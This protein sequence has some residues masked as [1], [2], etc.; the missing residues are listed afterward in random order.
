MGREV[1]SRSFFAFYFFWLW[2]GAA[3]LYGA[4]VVNVLPA[5]GLASQLFPAIPLVGVLLG[6]W[7]GWRGGPLLI[8][9]AFVL[10]LLGAAETPWK[11]RKQSLNQLSVQA[12]IGWFAGVFIGAGGPV[13]AL[14]AG[15]HMAASVAI[16]FGMALLVSGMRSTDVASASRRI[17]A[18]TAVALSLAT[19]AVAERSSTWASQPVAVSAT[20]AIAASV[21]L[22][23]LWPIRFLKRPALWQR[24]ENV[25]SVLVAIYFLDPGSF[26]SGL[27]KVSGET[28]R[29]RSVSSLSGRLPT[30]LARQVAGWAHL[31]TAALVRLFALLVAVGSVA[32]LT[33][34]ATASTGIIVLPL[35]AF[36]V[37]I[38]LFAA[39]SIEDASPS[40]RRN[41]VP[42]AIP[43]HVGFLLAPTLL[44][45][46]AVAV[47]FQIH[48]FGGATTPAGL[49][50]WVVAVGVLSAGV[51]ASLGPPNVSAILGVVGAGGLGIVLVVRGLLPLILPIGA[52]SAAIRIDA[53]TDPSA[54]WPLAA[55]VAVAG[56]A[57]ARHARQRAVAA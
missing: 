48:T 11:L 42:S 20:V 47:G 34:G 18:I 10:F 28:L 55:L 33:G 16:G 14:A 57:V 37:G 41:H 15:V 9:R 5:V 6:W 45:L 12:T 27:R 35:L 56:L 13:A 49:A 46:A 44:V 50:W 54:V 30:P 51:Q 17:T 7:S 53:A 25:D 26:V 21:L 22:A 38:D 19:L 1:L 31:P 23:G 52:A 8:N 29:A 3:L 32:A 36:A 40:W 4:A 43:T 2:T 24:S 39:F